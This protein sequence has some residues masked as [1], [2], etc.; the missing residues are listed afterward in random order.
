MIIVDVNLL[1]YAV[2]TLSVH[3]KPAKK[4]WEDALSR[5]ETIGLPWST[6][7]GFIRLTTRSG[8]GMNPVPTDAA[9]DIVE[10]W[11]SVSTVSVIEPGGRHLQIV[12]N[13]LLQ[14]RM[15]GDLTSDAHLAALAL[16]HNAELCSSDRD[17]AKFPG[18]RWRDPLS[19]R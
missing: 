7:I 6:I 10:D 15:A 8:I 9:F 5:G 12:R 17:F 14:A 1:I 19:A 2:N 4:W 16:E 3:H 13:L 18:L 11:L